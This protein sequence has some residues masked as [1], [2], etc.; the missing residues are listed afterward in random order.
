MSIVILLGIVLRFRLASHIIVYPDSTLYLSLAKNILNG[1]FFIKFVNGMPQ[2]LH[3]LYSIMV[4][5]FWFIFRDINFSAVTVSVISGSMIFLPSYLLA[6]SLFGYQVA[7]LSIIILF[8]EPLTIHWSTSMLTESLFIF[9]FTFSIYLL[10]HAIQQEKLYWY[11]IA[12]LV[13]GLSYLSRIS[14]LPSIIIAIGWSIIFG[15]FIHRYDLRRSINNIITLIM[16]Y[17]LVLIPYLI[18]LRRVKGRW[19]LTEYGDIGVR[20]IQKSTSVLNHTD[21]PSGNFIYAITEKILLNLKDYGNVFVIVFL[22]FI[23]LIFIGLIPNKRSIKDVI[24]T[25]YPF[26]WISIFASMW[27]LQATK[28]TPDERIRYLSPLIPLLFIFIARGST[29]IFILLKE[30]TNRFFPDLQRITGIACIICLGLFLV[31]SIRYEW[32]TVK[33]FTSL[34]ISHL[35]NK[36]ERR[37]IYEALGLR[38]KREIPNNSK[39]MA[40]KPY[41]AYHADG[42][43]YYSLD[44]SYEEN[45][46]WIVTNQIGYVFIDRSLDPYTRPTLSFLLDPSLA[47]NELK[48]ILIIRHPQ[49]NIPFFI[50][51]QVIKGEAER[52]MARLSQTNEISGSQHN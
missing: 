3:P 47:P 30:K 14:G 49:K 17:L 45:L 13:I 20:I 15:L 44:A 38:L 1:Q 34:E 50:V 29:N 31:L 52:A 28:I 5:I 51:Y 27:L 12:G 18:Q 8:F 35:W 6:R 21:K 25:L 40:R 41:I 16:G 23:I 9:L 48:P 10:W 2:V 11:F 32:G 43:W 24:K 46:R 42:I 22:P 19:L 26:S 33:R 4:A 7:W 37:D 39:I 36:K